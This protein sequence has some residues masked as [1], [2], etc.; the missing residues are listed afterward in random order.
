MLRVDWTYI[1]ICIHRVK[2]DSSLPSELGFK[3]VDKVKCN[4]DPIKH[5]LRFKVR[6]SGGQGVTTSTHPGRLE[7]LLLVDLDELDLGFPEEVQHS[8]VCASHAASLRRSLL[9]RQV[10]TIAP[11]S[12]L[13]TQL[14]RFCK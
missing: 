3:H 4:P 8:F 10:V 6:R 14:K 7:L 13:R 9:C 1:Y 11:P 2:T 12:F 5:T